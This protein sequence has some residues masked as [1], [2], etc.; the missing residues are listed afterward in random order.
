MWKNLNNVFPNGA[1]F[2]LPASQPFSSKNA[3]CPETLSCPAIV[4]LRHHNTTP[5]NMTPALT[6]PIDL[7]QVCILNQSLVQKQRTRKV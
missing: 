6:M 1:S 3:Y 5:D 4:A 2:I 7:V